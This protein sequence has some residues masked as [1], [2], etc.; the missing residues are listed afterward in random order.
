MQIIKSRSSVRDENLT[1]K[2][3]SYSIICNDHI[4]RY[5]INMYLKTSACKGCDFMLAQLKHEVTVNVQTP[6]RSSHG[7]MGRFEKS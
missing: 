6:Y 4:I 1:K 3:I 2:S 7:C 5:D